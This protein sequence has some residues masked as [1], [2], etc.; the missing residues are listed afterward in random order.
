M[1]NIQV[2]TWVEIGDE[3]CEVYKVT[4][5][6]NTISVCN[7]T[8]AFDV[9]LDEV[10]QIFDE[11]PFTPTKTYILSPE[12]SAETEKNRQRWKDTYI[13]KMAEHEKAR[14]KWEEENNYDPKW[15]DNLYKKYKE[16]EDK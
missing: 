9:T 4:E 7:E 1:N 13:R 12:E 10:K 6:D 16:G 5:T 8:Q 2:G 15:I 14:K 3:Y 11:C